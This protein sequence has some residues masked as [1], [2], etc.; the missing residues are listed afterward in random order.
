MSGKHGLLKRGWRSAVSIL[1]VALLLSLGACSTASYPQP[2]SITVNGY[3]TDTTQGK[4]DFNVSA[5]ANGQVITTGQITAARTTVSTSGYSGN[6]SICGQFVVNNRITAAVTLDSTGSMSWNDP[7]NLRNGAA[8][9]F[10]DRMSNQDKAAVAS[11]DT[12]TTPSQGFRAIM[13]WEPLTSD[14]NRLK[15]AI[16][17]ATFARGNTNLWDAVADSADLV[18]N[19]VGPVALVLTDGEDNSS[20][21][22]YLDAANYAKNKGVKVYMLGLGQTNDAEMQEVARVTGGTFAR[23][24]DPAQLD[25]L[26]NNIFNAMRGAFCV[27]VVFTPNPTPGT[28]ITGT[29][30]VTV[31]GKEVSTDYDVTFR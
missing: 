5:L 8:K 25:Q 16:D 30:Y 31:N 18:T 7:N 20:R 14:Q 19:N 2:D 21:L 6:A 10:I 27:S 15:Q 26:F 24:D 3:V 11:F 12:R 23:A 1:V 17:S 9:T 13:V 29:L 28:R 4:V 22:T